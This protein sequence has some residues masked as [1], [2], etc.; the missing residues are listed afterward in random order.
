MTRRPPPGGL[1][2]RWP[3]M[4][5]RSRLLLWTVGVTGALLIAV[6]AWNYLNV[7]TRLEAEAR[8]RATF[9]AEG[10]ADM[11]DAHLGPLQGLIRGLALGLE[12]HALD[13]PFAAVRDL[14]FSALRDHPEIY[15]STVALLPEM[16]P[17]TW[18]DAAPYVW[19]D[20]DTLG[21]E[22]LD[23]GRGAHVV[24]DWFALPRFLAREVWS[25]PY[26]WTTGV[27]MVTFSA[28]IHL[29]TPNGPVFAGVVTCDIDLSWL[30]AVLAELPLGQQGY[31]L[32]MTRN[33][34][35]ISHPIH[36]L[37][38]NESVFSIAEARDDLNLRKIGQRMVSGDHGLIPWVSWWGGLETW[39]AWQPLKTANWIMATVISKEELEAEILRFSRNEALVAIL[40]LLVLV[41]A[42]WLVARSITRPVIALGEAAKTLASGDLDAPLPKPRG[43]DEVAEL[44][45]AFRLM[46]DNLKRY[47]ADL[48]ETTAARER[49]KAELTVAH[50]IQMDLVPK[51][52]PPF[53]E[54]PDL[55][56]YAIMEPAREVGGDFYD[57]FFLDEERLVLAIADVSGKGVP[58]ALFMAV[59]RSFLRAEFK[60]DADP[61]RVLTRVNQELAEAN[62]SCM[63]V[64]LFCAVYHT[65]SGE[66]AY[67]NAGHN[68]PVLQRAGGNVEWISRP[69]GPVAGPMPGL[70]YATGQCRLEDGDALLLYTDGVT[71][72]MDPANRLYG[73]QRLRDQVMAVGTGLD[74]HAILA[75][76]IA[77]IRAHAAGANQSDDITLLILRRLVSVGAPT[78]G[79]DES[80]APTAVASLSPGARFTLKGQTTMV[81]E[82]HFTLRNELAEIPPLA[83]RIE[84]FGEQGRLSVQHIYQLNLVLDELITN[85]VSYGYSDDQ[86][87]EIRLHLRIE[88]GRLVA[89]LSDDGKP[90]NPLEEAPA[91]VLEGSIEDRPIGGLGIH[92][93]RTL[94]DEVSYRREE[95][96]NRL[97]LV[98]HLTN[99]EGGDRLP[100]SA[101]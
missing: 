83:E 92:F 82:Q 21:Y 14:L 9:L 78:T 69:A 71:E 99:E 90:F 41:V 15:G 79:S 60:V 96:H 56:I 39:L 29:P 66:I 30:D 54:R 38:L 85:I 95:G 88:P 47:I 58:A 20:G 76:L 73:N 65:V 55:D 22:D 84:V 101:P 86:P 34:T 50:S 4:G 97:T 42:V 28:P 57:F 25:E 36:D 63:F 72:A 74:G 53:P 12:N 64:T 8:D 49:M 98:K 70:D 40:G 26:L 1:A 24:E 5:I 62:D 67:A 2:G 94:M 13:L 11:I 51:T 52:F 35:Y 93:M 19:R 61:G 59:T 81:V 68:P 77:D 32:L 6:I 33:G 48:A 10:S 45:H 31:S 46:R 17:V 80:A 7:L 43:K 37:I 27:K 87:H 75:H 23:L 91:A 16:K 18:P 44:T 3:G 89:V 100:A